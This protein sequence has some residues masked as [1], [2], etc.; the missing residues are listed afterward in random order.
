MLQI[1]TVELD[2]NS[3]MHCNSINV[4]NSVHVINNSEGE[5]QALV[6]TCLKMLKIDSE[7]FLLVLLA[8]FYFLLFVLI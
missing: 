6:W 2:G 7:H 3:I 4:V 1:G 8:F 5:L